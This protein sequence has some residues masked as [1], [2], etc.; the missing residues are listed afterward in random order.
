MSPRPPL[1][2]PTPI[3]FQIEFSL[4]ILE[5]IYVIYVCEIFIFQC[6]FLPIDPVEPNP[7]DGLARL[8]KVDWFAD[9]E[10]TRL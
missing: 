7:A 1:P 5:N 4:I 8:S 2:D 3:L 10:F 6:K 9:E